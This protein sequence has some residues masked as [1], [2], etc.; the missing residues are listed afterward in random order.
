MKILIAEDDPVPRLVLERTLKKWGHDVLVTAD[1]AEA[2]AALERDD[3]PKLAI[4]DWM[5]PG[6]DGP[7]I[8]RKVRDLVRAE[9]TYIILLT[10]KQE[11][12]DVVIG[13]QS[14]ADD[15][16]TKPFDQAELR[17][18]IQV[19]ERIV[20]LQQKLNDRVK[21]LED[22]LAQVT[23]LR[24]L[25]PICSYCRKVRDD[26]NYWQ[27]VESYMAAHADVRFSHGICPHCWSHVVEPELAKAK[28]DAAKRKQ[29]AG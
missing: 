27:E 26:Q 21:K 28:A 24:G 22:A 29:Q 6:F 2:W 4:L 10:A 17:S 5:M 11:K 1:G 23:Q 25:L 3:A 16:V 8:C 13:L 15:F 19:G 18:R 9:P 12:E 20:A 14:G 7:D